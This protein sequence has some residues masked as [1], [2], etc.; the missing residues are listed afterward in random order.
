MLRGSRPRLAVSTNQSS[1]KSRE[2]ALYD[3][4]FILQDYSLTSCCTVTV[5]AALASGAGVDRVLVAFKRAKA[6]VVVYCPLDFLI[7]VIQELGNGA[8]SFG[9]IPPC[10]RPNCQL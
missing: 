7:G 3:Y 8:L 5:R 6:S 9:N 1:D 4:W 10:L 2:A